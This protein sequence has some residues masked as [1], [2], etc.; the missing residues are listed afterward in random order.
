MRILFINKLLLKVSGGT[1]RHIKDLI[2]NLSKKG[3]KITVL[4]EIGDEKKIEDIMRNKNVKIIFMPSTDVS[5]KSYKKLKET[6]FFKKIEEN[7]LAWRIFITTKRILSFKENFGWILNSLKW[8]LNHKKEFDVISVHYVP[9]FE[10]A[11]F[12]YFLKRIPYVAFL[13]G[14]SFF[15]SDIVKKSKN[16][17]TISKFIK[18]K[19]ER[20]H[21]FSPELIPIGVN[22]NKFANFD[23]KIVSNIRKKYCKDGDYLILNAARLVRGKGVENMI[24]ASALALKKNKRLKFIVCGDGVERSELERRIR[25]LKIEK[26]FKLV[27]AFGDE[28]INYY[29]AADIF[30]HVPDLTNHFGI[31]YLEAMSSGVPIIASDYEATPST[32]GKAAILVPIENPEALSKAMIKLINNQK[33]KDKISKE[34]LKRVKNEFNWDKIIPKVE[35]LYRKAITNK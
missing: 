27:R 16:V 1:E 24:E 3:H 31:V 29:H 8:V 32:V 22:F 18:E 14:Y 23:K 17:T 6:S 10:I 28:L 12:S 34:G 9:E 13:E 33:I 2:I 19:C 26:N 21:G 20:V 5:I 15:E 7:K 25:K 11:K 4:T 30:V 35:E